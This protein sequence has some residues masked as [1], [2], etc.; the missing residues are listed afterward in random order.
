M[1][2]CSLISSN[3]RAANLQTGNT[4]S[5][6]VLVRTR[7]GEKAGQWRL[8]T[9]RGRN[10]AGCSLI[11]SNSR[12]ANLQTR[13]TK[14]G[15]VLV[16]TRGGGKGRPVA[17]PDEAGRNHAELI[18]DLVEL[19]SCESSAGNT[20]SGQVLVR[21]RKAKPKSINYLPGGMSGAL[22]LALI[23]GGNMLAGIVKIMPRLLPLAALLIGVSTIAGAQSSNEGSNAISS[24][25]SGT[26]V[27]SIAYIDA[28]P[29]YYALSNPD[30]CVAING[31]LTSTNYSRNY[32]NGAVIDVRGILPPVGTTAL[33]CNTDPFSGVTA[34]STILLPG[35]SIQT[36][37]TW[38]LPSNTRIIGEGPGHNNYTEVQIELAGFTGTSMVQMGPTSGSA[39]G[40]AIEHIRFDGLGATTQTVVDGIDNASAG[41]G[42]YVNDVGIADIGPTASNASIIDKACTP[43]G[44][45]VTGL[46][47]GP[48]ATYSG[49]YSNI[50]IKPS[51]N[52]G[53]GVMCQQ[54][55]CVKIQAQTRG[56]HGLTCTGFSVNDTNWPKAAIYLDAYG[57][58]IENVHVEGFYD[59]I[60]VGDYADLQGGVV[61]GD[62][63]KA[64]VGN[65]IADLTGAYGDG[66]VQNAVHICNPSYAYGN[67]NPTACSSTSSL[68]VGNL[69]LSQ[70][71]SKG[72]GANCTNPGFCADAI[73]DDNATWQGGLNPSNGIAFVG[74]Y[75]VGISSP[76]NGYSRFTTSPGNSPSPATPTW[77]VGTT[78]LIGVSCTN[79]GAIYS[80]TSGSANSK[81][82][83]FV[84][85]VCTPG[86]CTGSH[87][88]GIGN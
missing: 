74:L 39:T 51:S 12:A 37:T 68:P 36:V 42:S 56:L 71:L 84:C 8:R 53:S 31:I 30:L 77:G 23:S 27:P 17:A 26:I 28:S 20:K 76:N 78:N 49:P 1:A 87:W 55:A 58:T 86:T 14:S 11:S 2:G 16:R 44:G 65:T 79:N 60:V 75:T 63:S 47:I 40:V 5:G 57:T 83:I 29:F 7:G 43:N 88:V 6:Q 41:D 59:A 15:Q 38:T 9:R 61:T 81:N 35:T 34:P 10:H 70:I 52:C 62:Q 50:A 25:S 72:N 3:S 54:T 73:R 33:T 18:V 66:P 80:N 82:T 4:K 46:C 24:N 45:A 69:V 13:N 19:P 32:P 21:A 67:P 64:V 22:K 85:S 48:G